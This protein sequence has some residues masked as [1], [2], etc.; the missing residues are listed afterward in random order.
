VSIV[1]Q[2]P[3]LEALAD[4]DDRIRQ[5]EEDLALRRG[6]LDS[7]KAEIER[8][9]RK[10]TEGKDSLVTME[11]TR[12]ELMAEVRQMNQQIERSREKLSRSR[13]ERESMAAQRE[14]EELRKLVRDRED[15]MERLGAV[16]DQARASVTEAEKRHG[17][18]RAELE[19][20]AEGAMQG[21]QDREKERNGLAAERE[22]AVKRLPPVLYRRYET[23]RARKP[24]AIAKTSNGTCNGCNIAVPPMMFQQ[25]LRREEFEQCPHCRRILYY[26]PLAEKGAPGA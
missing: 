26:Q 1:D 23:I 22:L 5:L 10:V 25:M 12:G 18:L 16:A 24:R 7:L 3:L 14:L 2:I 19:G 17:E 8:L 15:E 9:E 11:K 6:G 21:L 20:S 4:L 13:N